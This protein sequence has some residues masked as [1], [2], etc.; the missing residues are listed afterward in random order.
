MLWNG[1]C[2]KSACNIVTILSTVFPVCPGGF[3][4]LFLSALF[5]PL[6]TAFSCTCFYSYV[7]LKAKLAPGFLLGN[8][9]SWTWAELV[10]VP[11]LDQIQCHLTERFPKGAMSHRVNFTSF[12]CKCVWLF[13]RGHYLHEWN[14]ARGCIFLSYFFQPRSVFRIQQPSLVLHRACGFACDCHVA[15]PGWVWPHL[16]PT[17]Q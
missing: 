5:L 10:A 7:F 11:H 13:G 15:P 4:D 1:H 14:W 12:F 8:G 16:A 3:M 9:T 6:Q 17:P 2:G